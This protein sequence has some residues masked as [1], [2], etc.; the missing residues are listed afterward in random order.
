MGF[1]PGTSMPDREWW[2]ALWP[3]PEGVLR[4]LGV[5]KGG[6]AVDLCCGD[7]Y[8]TA[9]LSRLVSPGKV[10]GVELEAETVEKAQE[11]VTNRGAENCVVVYDDA[12][13]LAMHLPEPADFVLIANTFH[14]IPDP[15][16]REL[17]SKIHEALKPGGRFALIN[18][19]QVP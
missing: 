4:K 8:F 11:Y 14:G 13:N 1:F 9:P 2:S 19:H 12:R 6:T 10:Y 18:W 5:S 17:T 7:G 15:D 3:D 16:R